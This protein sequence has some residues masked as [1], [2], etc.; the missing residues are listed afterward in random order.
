MLPDRAP[1]AYLPH[2]FPFLLLDGV[3]ERQPGVAARA[4]YL[5]SAPL[6]QLLLVELAAQTA[7]IAAVGQQGEGGFLASVDQ[8]RFGRPPQPGELFEVSVRVIRSFGRLWM[9]EGEVS[10]G[11]DTLLQITLTLGTGSL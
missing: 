7:G 11:A 1:A 5:S 3:L 9:V 6:P 10:A 2:R 4:R 8:A